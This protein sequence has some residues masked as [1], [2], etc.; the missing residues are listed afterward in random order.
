M[1]LNAPICNKGLFDNQTIVENTLPA[2]EKA[3]DCGY[4]LILNISLTKDNRLVVCDSKKS[5][6][7][8]SS[9]KKIETLNYDDKENFNLSRMM[10]L[11][12]MVVL[13][14]LS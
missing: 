13:R 8:L 6:M 12:P 14:G 1:I 10:K 4:N 11:S 3:I 9:H 2:I 7:L 5:T